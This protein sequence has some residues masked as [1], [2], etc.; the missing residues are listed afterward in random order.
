[1]SHTYKAPKGTVFWFN[2]DF[3]GDVTI[4]NDNCKEERINQISIPGQDILAFVAE[5]YIRPNRIAVLEDETP[6]NLL[7]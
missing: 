2:P 6:E 5:E 4:L 3:S 1:M 7:K